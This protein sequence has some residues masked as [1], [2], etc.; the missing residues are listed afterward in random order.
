MTRLLERLY[1]LLRL[2]A[3]RLRAIVWRVRGARIG[4]KASLGRNAR[5]DRPW[6]LRAGT[7]LTVEADV[8]FKTV[9]DSAAIVL[10][11][12]V[13]IGRGTELNVI[14]GLTIGDHTVIAPGCFLVDHDHGLAGDR[15]IDQQPCAGRPVRIGKDVWIGARAIILPGVTVG[16]RAVIGA[17]AVVTHDVPPGAIAVGV[18]ARVVGQRKIG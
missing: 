14:C 18:P 13:F 7:R 6:T 8:W 3:S 5:V 16:N 17:G 10:G 1:E 12:H 15:R 9:L 2:S 11:D 4:N